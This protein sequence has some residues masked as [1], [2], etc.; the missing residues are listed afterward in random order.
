MEYWTIWDIACDAWLR[1]LYPECRTKNLAVV[2]SP[3]ISILCH[4]RCRHHEN[5][6]DMEPDQLILGVKL[7]PTGQ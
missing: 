2:G 1:W 3:H 4:G 5:M 7:S 6:R